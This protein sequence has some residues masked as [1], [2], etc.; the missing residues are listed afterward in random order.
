MPKA[1]TGSISRYPQMLLRHTRPIT[2]VACAELRH[3][4]PIPA[5]TVCGCPRLHLNR[6][7]LPPSNPDVTNFLQG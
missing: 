4:Q 5:W 2:A 6:Q 1:S 7:P 3:G